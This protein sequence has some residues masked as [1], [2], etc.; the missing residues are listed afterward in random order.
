MNLH[1]KAPEHFPGGDQHCFEWVVHEGHDDDTYGIFDLCP[2][3]TDDE[4]EGFE[5][6]SAYC[7][8]RQIDEAQRRFQAIPLTRTSESEEDYLAAWAP[9][10]ADPAR[11]QARFALVAAI[12]HHTSK[13]LLASMAGNGYTNDMRRQNGEAVQPPHPLVIPKLPSVDRAAE[14]SAHKIVDDWVN[15]VVYS[16]EQSLNRQAGAQ[17][18]P[19]SG[20]WPLSAQKPPGMTPTA[21]T[22]ASATPGWGKGLHTPA[23]NSTTPGA[24][25]PTSEGAGAQDKGQQLR[26]QLENLRQTRDYLDLALL[27]LKNEPLLRD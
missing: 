27:R 5:E 9:L 14:L 18:Q 11:E 8:Q 26:W 16:R 15:S 22:S 25:G 2:M 10:P 3:I 24:G 6:C 23:L 13:C 20:Y 4:T 21:G 12:K 19:W 17:Q 7:C 1:K